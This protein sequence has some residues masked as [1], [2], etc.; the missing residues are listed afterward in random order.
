[1]VDEG[2]TFADLKGTLEYFA[3]HCFGPETK[4]RLRP[5]YFPFVEPGAEVDVL[6]KRPGKDKPEWIEILGAGMVHPQVLRNVGIDAEKYTG[7]AFGMGIER[8]IM[9]REQIG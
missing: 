8:I 7:F 6:F 2:I 5:S 4:V 1:M 9:V 3:K